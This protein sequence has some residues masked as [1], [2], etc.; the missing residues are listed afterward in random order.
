VNLLNCDGCGGIIRQGKDEVQQ[1]RLS[2]CRIE[3]GND[4]FE[5]TSGRWDFCTVGCL[6]TWATHQEIE[7]ARN[8]GGR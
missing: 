2:V 3:P 7:T 6:A 1:S 8:E 5:R 4:I